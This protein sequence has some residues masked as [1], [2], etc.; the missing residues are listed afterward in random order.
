MSKL[1]LSDL[2]DLKTASCD[3]LKTP[4]VSK[5]FQQCKEVPQKLGNGHCTKKIESPF[6]RSSSTI[7]PKKKDVPL[8]KC[9]LFVFGHQNITLYLLLNMECSQNPDFIHFLVFLKIFP[10]KKL[11]KIF[12]VLYTNNSPI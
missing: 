4:V 8:K 10:A 9:V 7:T 6:K 12:L 3:I 1:K 2:S 11:I 5:S